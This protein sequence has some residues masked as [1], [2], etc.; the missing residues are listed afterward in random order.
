[1]FAIT[2]FIIICISQC[3][4]FSTLKAQDFGDWESTLETTILP[5]KHLRHIIFNGYCGTI[6]EV[7]FA[8]YLMCKAESLTSM[9]INHVVD[10]SL[11]DINYQKDLICSRSKASSLG[12][13]CFTRSKDSDTIRRKIAEFLHSVALN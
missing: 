2:D 8:R 1:M 3:L 10:W 7:E 4:N 5:K 9:E 13:L 12:C 11:E 6:G